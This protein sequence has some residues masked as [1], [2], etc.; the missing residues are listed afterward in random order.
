MSRVH[1]PSLPV[2]HGRRGLVPSYT[3]SSPPSLCSSGPTPP[4]VRASVSD[5][6]SLSQAVL[7]FQEA[8]TLGTSLFPT[9]CSCH[10]Q[11]PR[12][13]DFIS[14]LIPGMGTEVSVTNSP[15]PPDLVSSARSGAEKGFSDGKQEAAS[16]QPS[17]QGRRRGDDR[18][19]AAQRPL[20]KAVWRGKA[21]AVGLGV[22]G[23]S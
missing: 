19:G 14:A 5:M 8:Q 6:A 4:R 22:G 1:L 2:T 15:E 10:E 23:G 3:S 9:C 13:K 18:G 16:G 7:L 20:G 21:A 17:P 11:V 12:R